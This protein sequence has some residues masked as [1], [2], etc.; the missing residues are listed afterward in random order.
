[1]KLTMTMFLSL[2]GVV[3]APGGPGEDSSGGFEQGGW[4]V[5]YVDEDMGQAV[6]GWFQA[7]D[8][9]LLGRRT[10][11]IFAAHW[12]RVTDED[13]PVATP[14]N[15]LPK[16]VA[17]RTLEKTEWSGS[18]L[19]GEDVPGRVAELKKEPGRELQIHGS[20][21]LVQSLMA[22][23]LIDK[24]R[25]LVFPVVLGAGKR[26]FTEG[27]L[28]TAMRLKESRTTGSGVAVLAYEP[29]GQPSYGSFALEE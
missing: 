8:A 10:Y 12:P 7:A 14:L 27:A 22:R 19:L 4:V 11:E 28:P 23:D 15:T 6:N 17:S 5:P 29:A 25:L 9:F 26:L 2:D 1:M 21:E 16:Y 18:E 24:Y 3:Q 20:R 13:D